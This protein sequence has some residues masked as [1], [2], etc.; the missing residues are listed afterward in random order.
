MAKFIIIG[1]GRTG[2]GRGASFASY[3]QPMDDNDT[4]QGYILNLPSS[5]QYITLYSS[6]K[7]DSHKSIDLHNL[8]LQMIEYN[9]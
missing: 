5:L 9:W 4:Q 6:Q 7:E 1:G 3:S 2:R 8:Q